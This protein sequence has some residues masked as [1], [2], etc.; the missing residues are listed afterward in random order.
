MLEDIGSYLLE[1][2]EV[3]AVAV[4]GAV[5]CLFYGLS[6]LFAG[7]YTP[8]EEFERKATRFPVIEGDMRSEGSSEQRMYMALQ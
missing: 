3:S 1:N 6:S 5:A 2:S 8:Q 7:S 4:T